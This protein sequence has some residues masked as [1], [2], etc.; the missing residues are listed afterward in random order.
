MS[1]TEELRTLLEQTEADFRE[2]IERLSAADLRRRAP[3]SSWNN[4]QLCYHISTAMPQI[5]RSV[6]RLKQGKGMNPPSPLVW[7]VMRVRDPL[8]KFA[9][10][11]A[12]PRS[13]IA[14]YG[15]GTAQALAALNEITDDEFQRSAVILGEP[16]TVADS[17]H[18][19]REHFEEHRTTI[20]RTLG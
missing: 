11:N 15:S 8:M 10:R 5:L 18:F 13:M 14:A 1:E 12:T 2:L 19:I 7:T 6:G 9:A 3:G 17:F 4:R 16:R 20:E